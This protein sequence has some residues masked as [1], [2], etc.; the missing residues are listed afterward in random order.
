MS[1]TDKP[2][3]SAFLIDEVGSKT[4]F[5]PEDFTDEQRM[6]GETVKR[7]MDEEVEPKSEELDHP[8]GDFSVLVG[9]LKKAGEVGLLMTDVPEEYG[10][11]GLDKT[12]SMLCSELIGRQGSFAVTYGAHTGIGTLPI[13][14]F[15]TTEQKEK[16]LPLLATG[17]KLAAYA[18][19]EP[20][21][22][23]D[24]MAAKTTAVLSEDGSH[25]VLNGTKMWI[26]NAGFADVF[27]VFCQ[28][29]GNKF[30][31]FLVEAG[32]EGLSTGTEEKKL[33]LKGSS[34]RM[35]ILEDVKVP[36][37]N[38][39]GEIGRGHKIAFNILNFGRFKLGV[40]TLGGAKTALE[41]AAR[42]A[43]ERKQFGKPI[44]SFGAIGQKLAQ[45][46]IQCYALESM[47]YRVA[48]YMDQTISAID[49][50]A[51]DYAQQVMAAIEEFAVEDSIMKVHGSEVLDFVVDEAMQVFGGYGYSCEYPAE[52]AYRDSRINRIFEGTNEINRL[53]IPGILLKR[54]MKGQLPL[55][56]AIA[57][58]ETVLGADKA[59]LPALGEGLDRESFLVEKAKQLTIH[60]ANQ[61]IQK[62]MAGLKD[63]QELLMVMADMLIDVYALD[64]VVGRGLQLD[65]QASGT[66][67][68]LLATRAAVAHHY[69]SVVGKAERLYTHLAAGDQNQLDK[70]LAVLDK[71]SYRSGIDAIGLERQLAAAT[72]EVENYPFK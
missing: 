21:S 35:L 12:T 18:L 66:G 63:Q 22:G 61:T 58:V 55:F 56:G 49:A 60:A 50:S 57:K 40:G 48:G 16:W 27:T 9:L 70:H 10:G 26:T 44:S 54:A 8:D 69:A 19:T 67:L 45:M 59:P 17:E 37:G 23:S 53:L 71:L 62:H 65:P 33:G 20:G 34:T 11:L 31:A 3:G 46:S 13:T 15:G 52:R 39:L 38:L 7:F 6:F 1:G 2:M 64:S 41:F 43:N 24:A 51:P 68:K 32:S 4:I 36:V 28:V 29:D 47:C 25:Y 5:S 14:F 30:T 42:Y 72:I